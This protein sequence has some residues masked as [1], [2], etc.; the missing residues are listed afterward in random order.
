V[1]GNLLIIGVDLGNYAVKTSTKEYFLSKISETEKLT[2]KDLIIYNGRKLYIGEGEFQ[3]DW[4]KSKKENLLPFLFYALAQN[5]SETFFQVVLGLPIQQY[6]QNKEGLKE[7]ILANRV[8]NLLINGIER[9]I[10]ITDLEVAPEGASVYYQLKDSQKALIGNKPLLIVDIGGRTTNISLFKLKG[11]DRY[12]EAYKTIPVGMLNIYSD[13]V[14]AI[15]EKFTQSYKL[16][17]GEDILN[18]GLCL[19]GK[20]QNISFIQPL[21]KKQFDSIMKEINLNFNID[22]GYILLTGGGSKI[23]RQPFQNRLTNLIISDEPIYD[24]VL[25]FQKV[26]EALWQE[27]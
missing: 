5:S 13:I 11:S 3:T 21:I 14:D 25:G 20:E 15:N 24:N 2:N 8:Q 9:K 23:L 27:N 4:N 7:T 10:V 22:E 12:I 16:E 1:E 26:G 6:K 19:Y 17:D 18:N